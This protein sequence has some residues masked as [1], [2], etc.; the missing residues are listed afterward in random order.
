[1]DI[2]VKL[3]SRSSGSQMFCEIGVLINFAKFTGISAR[4]FVK[5]LRTPLFID[6]LRM[7]ASG[8]FSLLRNFYQLCLS[9]SDL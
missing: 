7:T 3:C 9:Y 5:L 8:F 2:F 4:N 6:L 1:M